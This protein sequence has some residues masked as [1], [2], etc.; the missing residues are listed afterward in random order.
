MAQQKKFNLSISNKGFFFVACK[1]IPI[2]FWQLHVKR[3]KKLLVYCVENII[4]CM[5]K[6]IDTTRARH[7]GCTICSKEC[8]ALR[9][10][11]TA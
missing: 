11:H 9:A 2:L 6:L 7:I 8:Q 4:E 1:L 3:E 5:S 10:Q